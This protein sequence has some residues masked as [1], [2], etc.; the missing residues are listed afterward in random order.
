M[1]NKNLSTFFEKQLIKDFLLNKL[2]NFNNVYFGN[3][4]EL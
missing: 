1:Q 4:N 3:V 2:I